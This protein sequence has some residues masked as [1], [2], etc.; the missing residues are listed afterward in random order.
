[1]KVSEKNSI[2]LFVHYSTSDEIPY[3]VQ[4]YINELSRH[5]DQ[6][7]VLTNNSK[8][9]TSQCNFPKNIAF[10]FTQNRG[11]DFGM[12]YRYLIN[13]KLNEFNQIALSNDSNILLN[14]LDPVFEWANKN[15]AD[16]WGIIDSNE[17]PWFSTHNYNYH[18]QSHFIVFNENAIS[19]LPDFFEQIDINEILNEKNLKKLRRLVIDRWEIG[20]TQFFI[21][22]NISIQ[23]YFQYN[24]FSEKYKVQKPNITHSLFHELAA[25]GYP[26]LKKKIIK[27]EKKFLRTKRFNWENTINQY[28]HIECDKQKLIRS[29]Q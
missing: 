11:Y 12:F 9:K 6:V 5:F 10:H 17:K 20:L 23:S 25:E 1:M 24:K 26:F 3:S 13:K 22:H 15:H 2:C 29:L 16:F 28:A 4:I 19:L 14:H 8:I 27:G 7:Q 18:I 21:K